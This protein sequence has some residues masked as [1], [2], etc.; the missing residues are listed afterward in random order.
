MA[1][2]ARQGD[3]LRQFL[4]E[5]VTLCLIG[6]I[7]GL[8]IGIGGSAAFAKFGDWPILIDMRFVGVAIFGSA[9]IGVFFGF[10]PARRASQLNP[11]DAL[12]FE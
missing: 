6:G 10:Y 11:I 8:G 4:I 7:I 2:G 1:I 3:I 9:M 12:R 5:A